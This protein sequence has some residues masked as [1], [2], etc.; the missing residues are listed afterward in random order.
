MG[1]ILPDSRLAGGRRIVGMVAQF[2][3]D[4][5]YETFCEAGR[6]VATMCGDVLFV[7]VGDGKNYE[8]I[9]QRYEQPTGSI[10]FLGR[11]SNVEEIIAAFD[12]GVLATYIEGLPNSIME[13][14]ALGKPVVATDGGG[15][16]ELVVDGE[17]GFLVPAKDP[18]IVARRIEYLVT[19]PAEARAMGE[20][21]KARVMSAF[22]VEK[23]VENTLS[24]YRHLILE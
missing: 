16:A 2:K 9:R 5:D 7:A 4:K 19:H 1:L 13:Y 18:E 17:T 10:A 3:D 15:T 22:S 20:R 14:M 11:Q 24:I 12:V 6:L 8:A 23:L 21:G